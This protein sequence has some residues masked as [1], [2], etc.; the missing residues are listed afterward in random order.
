ME[1]GDI[2]HIALTVNDIEESKLFW[3]DFLSRIGYDFQ[4]SW[5]QDVSKPENYFGGALY[6]HKNGGT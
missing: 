2:N 4:G 6:G 5:T 3:E 1:T